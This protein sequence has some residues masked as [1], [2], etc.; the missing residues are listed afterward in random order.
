MLF[1]TTVSNVVVWSVLA[2]G[3]RVYRK[4]GLDETSS[5]SMMN[6]LYN[7]VLLSGVEFFVIY[8]KGVYFSVPEQMPNFCTVTVG[9][10]NQLS[11]PPTVVTKTSDRWKWSS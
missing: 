1:T 7:S 4:I 11:F 10:M 6:I 9:G 3:S 5:Y 2:I 8:I